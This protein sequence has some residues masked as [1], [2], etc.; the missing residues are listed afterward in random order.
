MN[1]ATGIIAWSIQMNTFLKQSNEIFNWCARDGSKRWTMK[2]LWCWCLR[3]K[4]VYNERA[5]RMKLKGNV[6]T[7]ENIF[8]RRR[9]SC[10]EAEHGLGFGYFSFHFFLTWSW[11]FLFSSNNANQNTQWACNRRQPFMLMLITLSEV[12]G[13]VYAIRQTISIQEMK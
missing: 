9:W 8:E 3:Q 7:S 10:C 13:Q 4:E 12:G 6:P 11:I 1:G 5:E 2:L